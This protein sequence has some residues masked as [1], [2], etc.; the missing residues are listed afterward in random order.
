MADIC[1]Q[2][3]V[4]DYEQARKIQAHVSIGHYFIFA[5]N[6]EVAGEPSRSV[7]RKERL[8]LTDHH[9]AGLVMPLTDSPVQL[10]GLTVNPPKRAIAPVGCLV[11]DRDLYRVEQDTVHLFVACPQ[12][13]AALHLLVE[14]N[15]E[16]FTEMELELVDGVGIET[17][18]MLLS[19]SYRARLTSEGREIGAPVSFTVAEYTLAPLSAR[20]L[21]HRLERT[22]DELTFNIGVES[23]QMPYTGSLRVALVDGDHEVYQTEL[24]PE[25]AG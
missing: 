4:T 12:P 15:G 22:G 9:A 21:S 2:I 14:Y 13:P 6:Q 7:V 5:D 19:G 17:L 3:E 1:E 18:P 8:H 20:L 10:A 25:M 16:P 23:Y 11:T 24:S